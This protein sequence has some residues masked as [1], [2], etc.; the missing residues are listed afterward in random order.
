[1]EP[2]VIAQPTPPTA[3]QPIPFPFP[4]ASATPADPIGGS[5]PPTTG[6]GS[7]TGKLFI[8]TLPSSTCFVDGQPKGGTPLTVTVP[9]GNHLVSCTAQDG[10]TTIKKTVS[11]N[12]A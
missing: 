5:S 6:G 3:P 9:A 12:V 8:N 11:A 2:A 7:G 4:S 1:L 10:G